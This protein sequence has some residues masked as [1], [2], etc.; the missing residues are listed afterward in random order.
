MRIGAFL[1]WLW[2]LLVGTAWAD[3]KVDQCFDEICADAACKAV[4]HAD[5]GADQ[6][7]FSIH[8][9]HLVET[10]RLHTII[11]S[12][13]QDELSLVKAELARRRVS[14]YYACLGYIN[15]GAILKTGS[16]GHFVYQV[17]EGIIQQRDVQV[18]G[19][20]TAQDKHYVSQ[21]LLSGQDEQTLNIH[22]MRNR[23]TRLKNTGL[24]HNI[25]ADISP[26]SLGKAAL[27]V[28]LDRKPS[29]F[30][31]QVYVDNSQSTYVG[32]ERL[33]FDLNYRGFDHPAHA[34][35]AAGSVSKGLNSARVS[36]RV[37]DYRGDYIDVA[38]SHSESVIIQSPLDELDIKNTSDKL[39][40][41]GYSGL[42][43]SSKT[44]RYAAES[45]Q[46]TTLG[47]FFTAELL[48]SH[49]TLLDETAPRRRGRHIV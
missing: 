35:S 25:K 18:E 40:L 21:I 4:P 46:N 31:G 48:Q 15:S 24:Y 20:I 1:L 41:T 16:K 38:L 42:W 14:E 39:S 9:N 2:V 37:A 5:Q 23:L 3:M 19:D 34:I 26:K 47:A 12:I 11:T 22:T 49:N 8:G 32:R 17:I 30:S 6:P 27:Q 10:H 33:G 7:A 13:L 45:S 44:G 43:Q 28:K 29:D 36:Y